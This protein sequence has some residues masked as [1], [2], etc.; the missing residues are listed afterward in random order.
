MGA[1]CGRAPRTRQRAQCGQLT[2]NSASTTSSSSAAGPGAGPGPAPASVSGC[3]LPSEWYTC[4]SSSVS[5]RMR[6]RRSVFVECSARIGHQPVGAGFD[7]HGHGIAQ[8]CQPTLYPIRRRV[9]LISGIDLLTERGVL[10]PMTLG[11]GNHALDLGG[12]EIAGLGDG[13]ALFLLG[14]LVARRHMQDAIGVDFE[15]HLDLGDAP[16][17]P[18]VSLLVGSGRALG[19]RLPSPAHPGE[20]RCPPPTGCLR[21]S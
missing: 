3:P 11:L 19:C 15:G 17:W 10:G 2:V 9:E 13:D 8:L 18:L 6:S 14:V 20:R 5:A 1:T 4:C 12:V 7:V 16:R 21:P